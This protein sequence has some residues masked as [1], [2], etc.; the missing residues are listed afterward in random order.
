M[1]MLRPMQILTKYWGFKSFRSSQEEIINELLAGRDTLA[2]L[3]TGG[4]KSMCYQ[5]T[6]MMQEGICLVVSPLIALMTDQVSSLQSTGIKAMALSSGMTLSEVD[7]ALDNCIYGSF[8]FLYLSPERLQNRMVQERLKKMQINLIAVDEAHCISEWGYDFRPAYLKISII[9]SFTNAP[10]LALTATAT[11]DVVE[12]IQKLLLFKETNVW[13]KSFL[14][15][16]LSYVV[17]EQEDKDGKLIRVLE[18]VKGSCIVYC[19]TR[20]ETKRIY[21]LLQKHNISSHFFHGG[22][23]I[24]DRDIKQ[25]QWQQNHVR[26]MVATNAFGMGIDKRNVRLVVHMHLPSSPEAYFQETGRAG[27]D[28]KMAYA[29]I[30]TNSFDISK[31]KKQIEEHY[32][33]LDEI[34]NVYQH[35]ANHLQIAIGSAQEEGYEFRMQ[36][37]C[38]KYKLPYLKT[39]NILKLLE[40]EG[41]IKLTNAVQL[42]SRIHFKIKH[43]E[44]YQFQIA[45]PI[46]DRFIKTIL[47]SYGEVF[48]RFT[49]IQENILAKRS[50]QSTQEVKHYLQKLHNMNILEYLPQNSSPK[51]FFCISRVEAKMLPISKEKLIKRKSIEESKAAVMVDYV[52]NKYRCRSSFVLEYFG[53]ENQVRCGICDICLER[54]KLEMSDSEFEKIASAIKRLI[55]EK[56]M[57]SDD[58]ILKIVEFKEH[59]MI[60]VIQF[61]YDNG[62]IEFTEDEKLIWVH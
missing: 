33:S 54:N 50:G 58:I 30:L 14:R 47:R 43:G 61:L 27:R 45:N 18:R 19:N 21:Q 38:D 16:K 32:P 10:L 9:R 26:V 62:Q 7:I 42:L 25:K 51:I 12:D 36:E 31:L 55:A 5:V 52:Q 34:S 40:R 35:L 53:E 15:P 1:S 24:I 37:F 22:I 60:N 8:K 4:G 6:S 17:L 28:E 3:P 49:K 39:H 57:R 13:S 2:L 46:Y 29:I 56:P 41:Y 20:K 23:D 11:P 59:K 44:L 48:N